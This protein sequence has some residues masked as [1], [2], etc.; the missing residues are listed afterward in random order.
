MRE[1]RISEQYMCAFFIGF[2]F[3]CNKST[4]S[5]SFQFFVRIKIKHRE[6]NVDTFIHFIKLK[7]E[8]STL[9]T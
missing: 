4:I 2:V 9:L 6:K 1:R 3:K 5:S 8:T 7:Y